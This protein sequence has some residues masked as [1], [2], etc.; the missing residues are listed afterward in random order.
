V[1]V[2]PAEQYA[3]MGYVVANLGGVAAQRT[4]VG[5]TTRANVTLAE[6][7]HPLTRPGPQ[8]RA[9]AAMLAASS[10]PLFSTSC[11]NIG[12]MGSVRVLTDSNVAQSFGCFG[13]S[14]DVNTRKREIAA[15]LAQ[16]S[17]ETTGEKVLFLLDLLDLN[18]KDD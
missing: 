13:T 6:P 18:A 11:L 15:F 14:G 12:T 5:L 7:L 9:A 3:Q 2:R 16:T 10:A 17:H 1:E 4:T 8:L